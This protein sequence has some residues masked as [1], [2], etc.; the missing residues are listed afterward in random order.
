MN[1]R[2]QREVVKHNPLPETLKHTTA[3]LNT[4]DSLANHQGDQTLQHLLSNLKNAAKSG[5]TTRQ[6]PHTT[7]NHSQNLSQRG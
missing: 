1:F 6:S 5:S 7:S 3:F 4:E 2:L